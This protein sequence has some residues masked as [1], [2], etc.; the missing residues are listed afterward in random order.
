MDNSKIA[1]IE[2]AKVIANDSKAKVL[3]PVCGKGFLKV[4]EIELPSDE[5]AER[6]LYCELCGA[7]NFMRLKKERK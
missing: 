3:C 1:W 2:A 5:I 6:R 7:E 4:Q